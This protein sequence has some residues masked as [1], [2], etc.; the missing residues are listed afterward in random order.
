[1]VEI[2]EWQTFP[3]QQPLP[4]AIE[5][6][7][8]ACRL[9]RTAFGLVA[10][11]LA[12]SALTMIDVKSRVAAARVPLNEP[13]PQFMLWGDS[14]ADALTF[15][16]RDLASEYHVTGKWFV[17]SE[18]VPL[19]EA[20]SR[21]KP[22]NRVT[23]R[24]M[25][26]VQ[27]GQ[28]PYVFIIA[29]WDW[30]VPR[31][32]PT[33]H[34]EGWELRALRDDSSTEQSLADSTRVLSRAL[35]RTINALSVANPSLKRIYFL[36]QIP[37]RDGERPISEGTYKI[38]QSGIFAALSLC[39]CDKLTV[40]NADWFRE[41]MSRNGDEDGCYYFDSNHISSH[42]ARTLVRPLL[43]PIFKEMSEWTRTTSMGVRLAATGNGL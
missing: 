41:G 29:R 34:D 18:L 5:A 42:G 21:L 22:A 6:A 13:S 26:E 40:L 31:W 43:E 25:D 39:K 1:M 24:V 4:P 36:N 35:P 19:V 15:L 23:E 30:R 9:L 32:H 11:W 20:Y 38:Q 17:G 8:P 28:V 33:V 27:V 16:F 7:I 3:R 14:H 2:F 12:A 10:V 37:C